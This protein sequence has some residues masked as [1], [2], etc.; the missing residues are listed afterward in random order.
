MVVKNLEFFDKDGYNLNLNWNEQKQIWEGN[1]FFPK[2]SVGLYENTTIYVVEYVGQN[3]NSDSDYTDDVYSYPTGDGNIVFQWDLANTFVDEF[4]MFNFD[5]DYELKDTSSLVYTPYDGPLCETLIINRFD[6]YN[7]PLLGSSQDFERDDLLEIHVAFMANEESDETTYK[8]TLVMSYEKGYTKYDIARITFFAE[9]IEED[10]RLKVWNE[11]LGYSLKPEDTIIFKHSDMHEYMPDFELLNEKRKELML[12][13]HNIY[14]YIGGYK[15]IINAIK[16][17]GYDNLNIVEYWRN[18]NKYDSEYG[19]IYRTYVYSLKDRKCLSTKRKPISLDTKNF[20]KLNTISLS[21]NI[22]HPEKIEGKKYDEYGLPNVIEDFDKDK[23]DDFVLTIEE[24]LVKLFALKK[25]LND[26]FMPGSSKITD[27]IGEGNY[28][29]INLIGNNSQIS[30]VNYVESKGYVNFTVFPSKHCYITE[31]EDFARFI[32]EKKDLHIDETIGRLGD[33]TIEELNNEYDGSDSDSDAN[34]SEIDTRSLGSIINDFMVEENNVVC[35]LYEEYYNLTY[36]NKLSNDSEYGLREMPE[37]RNVYKDVISDDISDD[38][39]GSNDKT[40]DMTICA[41]VILVGNF[42]DNIYD[43]SIIEWKIT[44]SD[45]EKKW[46][47]THYGNVKTF[48]KVFVQLPYLGNYDVEMTVWDVY[49]HC[50][51]KS[52]KDAIIVEPYSVDIRGFYY[53]ARPLPDGL[54]YDL[55]IPQEYL[56]NVEKEYRY[57]LWSN[58][59][60]KGIVTY[61]SVPSKMTLSDIFGVVDNIVEGD[62]NSDSD[63]DYYDCLKNIRDI[64][65]EHWVSIVNSESDGESDSESDVEL[66]IAWMNIESEGSDKLVYGV[67]VFNFVCELTDVPFDE[68]DSYVSDWNNDALYHVIK[69]NVDKMYMGAL[70]EH[71]GADD[72]N[73]SMRNY[74]PDG[75]VNFEGPY[76]KYDVDTILYRIEKGYKEYDHLNEEIINL[77]HG[78]HYKYVRYINSVV[79]IKPLTWVL[80]GFDQTRITGR[81]INDEY[82]KWTLMMIGD[83]LDPDENLREDKVITTHNGLYLTYLFENEGVYKVK[84]ELMDINGNKYDIEKSI[85]IVDRDANYEMYH[86]LN[87]EYNVYLEA[88]NERN[89]IYL[90]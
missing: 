89:L 71:L 60:G 16:F 29:G 26:E 67:D 44:H 63:P 74:H 70:Q 82:P 76:Y 39:Y 32:A 79:N 37:P 47:E 73:T 3:S 80:L 50:C 42:G 75:S 22:N 11:N 17:F 33:K 72:E 35:D 4:F 7:V 19:K 65:N 84:L 69:K 88:K 36:D 87:D 64:D 14:P 38:P 28:F 85:I 54:K 40:P 41:K 25:K 2:V 43:S 13:G 55:M 57:Y 48:S 30:S 61:K 53:D 18:I 34:I 23:R 83:V 15:A 81:V 31:N 90:N 77:E 20:Q 46:T 49:N 62:Y 78:E 1:I 5:A 66:K 27:V 58:N 86:T 9:T 12:E 45:P 56:D 51:K 6:K 21:Y 68:N 59:E 52:I 8:R 10:E 24:A